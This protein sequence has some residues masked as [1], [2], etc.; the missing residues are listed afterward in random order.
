VTTPKELYKVGL[1]TTR[2]LKALGDLIVG[3]LLFFCQNVL[4]RLAADRAATEATALDLM[5]LPEHPF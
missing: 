2:L 3:W 5:E 1:N 4:P